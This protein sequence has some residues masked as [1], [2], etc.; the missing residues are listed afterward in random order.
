MRTPLKILVASVMFT[1]FMAPAAL[2]Q[3][4]EPETPPVQAEPRV[5]P[6][7]DV[8]EGEAPNMPPEGQTED[9]NVPA[10]DAYS[11]AG[12]EPDCANLDA[13]AT[14]ETRRR[15][16]ALAASATPSQPGAFPAGWSGAS[17]SNA[18]PEIQ[19]AISDG[20]YTT[21]DLNRAMLR[22]LSG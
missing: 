14:P 1:A 2:A 3:T 15:C 18:P 12:A 19:E 13:M 10:Y 5:L 20:E 4:P 11:G 8:L 9:Q 6:E 17:L 7:R 16:E 22:H 21:E